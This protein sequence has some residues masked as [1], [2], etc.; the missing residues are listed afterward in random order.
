MC[1]RNRDRALRAA[2]ITR[3]KLRNAPRARYAEISTALA[4]GSTREGLEAVAGSLDTRL[5]RKILS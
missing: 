3:R 4:L 2:N 5:L 1:S